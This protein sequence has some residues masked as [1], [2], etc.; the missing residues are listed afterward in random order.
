MNIV[1]LFPTAVG[2]FNFNRPLTKEEYSFMESQEKKPNEGN[3]TSSDRKILKHEQFKELNDFIQ[4]SIDKYF[5][6]VY[7]PEFDVKLRITQSWLNYTEPGQYHHKH[8]HPNSVLSAVFYVDADPEVDK[9]YFYHPKEY[10]QISFKAKDWNVFNS[11]SWWLPVSSGDLV[12]FP[13]DFWHSV[14][15]KS[16]SNTRIS[17]ALNTFPVG[18]VGDDDSLTGLH[19]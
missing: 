2:R 9:I 17:L 12:V 13:S 15:T 4:A 1:S 18:Y 11:S 6:E 16:G 19:L 14:D 5:N 7:Q 8:A 3:T 10:N